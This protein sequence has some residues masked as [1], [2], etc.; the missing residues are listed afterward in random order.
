VREIRLERVAAQER[1]S[2][3]DCTAGLTTAS[4]LSFVDRFLLQPYGLQYLRILS[5]ILVIGVAGS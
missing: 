5:F 3:W 1:A 2:G 4:G